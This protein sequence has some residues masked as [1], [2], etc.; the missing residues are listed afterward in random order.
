[1]SCPSFTYAVY[2]PLYV[3]SQRPLKI[4]NVSKIEE[5][6]DLL[7]WQEKTKYNCMLSYEAFFRAIFGGKN[8]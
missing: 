7:I 8:I 6:G 2:C 4:S 5:I 1:M 3:T